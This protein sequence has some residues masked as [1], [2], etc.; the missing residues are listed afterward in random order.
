[1]APAAI[2][3]TVYAIDAS[4]GQIKWKHFIDN[5]VISGG[6]CMVSGGV[7]YFGDRDG[8]L[9]ALDAD[10][11][12]PLWERKF[13]AIF[14]SP[15]SIGASLNGEMTL[16][17]PVSGGPAAEIPGAIIALGLPSEGQVTANGYL[18]LVLLLIA[19]VAIAAAIV[20]NVTY[21]KRKSIAGQQAKNSGI[22]ED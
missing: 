10:N 13:N 14:S 22:V 15:P 8:R 4:T 21:K 17:V 11:G 7:V 18:T 2:N 1:M 19:L 20:Q 16:F 9:Y 3:T 6:C 12:A 5:T